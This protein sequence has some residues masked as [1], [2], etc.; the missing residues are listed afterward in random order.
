MR[1][2]AAIHDKDAV[3]WLLS[4]WTAATFQLAP[5]LSVRVRLSASPGLLGAFKQAGSE[6]LQ[7]PR[8]SQRGSGDNCRG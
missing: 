4:A 7:G 1:S 3:V 2:L 6:C 5:F 8:G